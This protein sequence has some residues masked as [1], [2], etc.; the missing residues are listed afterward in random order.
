MKLWSKGLGKIDLPLRLGSAETEAGAESVRLRGR[1]IEG[2]VNWSYVVA[3]DGADLI[4][5]T[6]VVGDRRVLDHLARERGLRLLVGMA[7]A[8]LRFVGRLLVSLVTA[9]RLPAYEPRLGEPPSLGG[10]G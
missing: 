1:I 2:K 5:F 7:P 6:R 4:G 10:R 8:L 3:I 9:P